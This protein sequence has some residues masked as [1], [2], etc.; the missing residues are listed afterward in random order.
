MRR[1]YPLYPVV[2]ALLV[3]GNVLFTFLAT[4]AIF[5]HFERH[6]AGEVVAVMMPYYFRYDLVLVVA[7][8][9]L[10][11]LAAGARDARSFKL[12]ATLLGVALVTAVAVV[13]WLYPAIVEVRARVPSF[14]ADA[15]LTEA[16]LAFRRLHGVSSA[17]NVLLLAA[18]TALLLLAPNHVPRDE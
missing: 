13:F 14:A 6:A 16:R 5:A 4:P 18:G 3:G 15:P 17:L 8:A 10:F 12:S 1:L 9:L 7:A 11:A 2:L